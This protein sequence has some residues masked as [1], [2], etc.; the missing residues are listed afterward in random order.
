MLLAGCAAEVAECDV[1]DT[2]AASEGAPPCDDQGAPQTDT[3]ALSNEE[4]EYCSE[5]GCQ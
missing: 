1:S 4:Q 2:T 5:N 3:A